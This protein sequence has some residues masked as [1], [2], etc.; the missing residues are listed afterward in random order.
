MRGLWQVRTLDDV[1]IRVTDGSHYSP[2]TQA[3]GYP[4]ITVRDV[5]AESGEIDLRGC[6]F[7]SESDFDDLV[8]NGCA[9]K[10]GDVLFSKDGTVGKVALVKSDEN[11][12]VLSSLAILTPDEAVISPQYLQYV[13]KSR[14]FLSEAVGRKTGVAIRRIVLKNL[15]KITIPIPPL[16]DQVKIVTLL[17]EAFE[18]LTLARQYTETNLVSAKEL[19]ESSL[20]KYFD[21]QPSGASK[22]IGSIAQVKGGKRLPKGSKLTAE[23]T[24]FPYVAVKNFNDRGGVDVDG[25]MFVPPEVQ[26][27]IARY[28]ISSD[29]LY[30]SI[31]GTIGK[32]GIV[33]SELCG[34]NLT[35]NAAKLVLSD[36][37]QNR[38]LY[39]FTKTRDFIDQA[40]KQTRTAAQPKLA[41]SRLEQI[42]VPIPS[43]PEQ[44][45][46]IQ[47][48][49]ILERKFQL[50][51]KHYSQKLS[52]IIEL[53]QSLLQRAFAGELT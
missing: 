21:C 37:V 26:P 29:D 31:A 25:V 40:T 53:R 32:T 12:V 42:S 34:A 24:G 27:Q 8:K 45:I 49:D 38:Y 28:T 7:V 14:D 13:L 17:D 35:E 39:Y 16:E 6:K 4:Y 44:Q 2:K 15:K 18:G 11:F 22:K 5:D 46:A 30:V 41:L 1:C 43:L 33:P 20:Q 50:A 52:D 36:E 9:P 3:S 10:K 51:Q 47:K 23:D 19:F 48:F